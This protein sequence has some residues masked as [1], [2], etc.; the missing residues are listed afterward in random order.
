MNLLNPFFCLLIGHKLVGEITT[1]RHPSL[2]KIKCVRC[3]SD[4]LVFKG[5]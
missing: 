2:N 3:G 1:T 4:N 5:K